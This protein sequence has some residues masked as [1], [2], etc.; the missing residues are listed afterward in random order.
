MTKKCRFLYD[1]SPSFHDIASIPDFVEK[2]QIALLGSFPND[3][4]IWGLSVND[5][6]NWGLWN[7]R[8]IYIYTIIIIVVI[9]IML[10]FTHI[11]VNVPST[12]IGYVYSV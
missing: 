11:S 9:I 12:L 10:I 4:K 2:P 1:R 7:T 6:K 8:D 3:P 5:P